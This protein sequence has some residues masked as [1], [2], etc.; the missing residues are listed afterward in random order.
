MC[1]DSGLG[2][3]IRIRQ[4]P[5]DRQIEGFD[6]RPFEPGHVYDVSSRLGVFLIVS[7]FAEP[8]MR[9]T[10]RS[11]AADTHRRPRTGKRLGR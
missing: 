10:E 2:V 5:D 8:E 3:K 9:P 4:L 7:N 6:L 11:T 1:P